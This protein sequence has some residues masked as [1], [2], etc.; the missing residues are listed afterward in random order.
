MFQVPGLNQIETRNESQNFIKFYSPEKQANASENR[1][2]NIPKG[3]DRLPNTDFQGRV[4]SFRQAPTCKVDST[5]VSHV[6]VHGPFGKTF[7]NRL[8]ELRTENSLTN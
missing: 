7:G 3:K 4:V 8:Y 5:P 1:P 2:Y 6:L